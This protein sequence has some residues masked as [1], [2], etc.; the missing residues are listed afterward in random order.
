MSK[1]YD[2][3]GWATRNDLKCSDGRVIRQGAFKDQD[4]V[5]VPL[6]WNHNH[7]E[8]S[9]V[10]GHAL[11]LNRPEGIYTYG[12]FNDTEAG[13]LAKMLVTHGDIQ[14]LSIY[15][16]Q[17][18]QNGRDVVH[19]MIREVSL[20]LAGANPGAYIDTILTHSDDHDEEAIIY[21][22]DFIEHS[23]GIVID[24][25]PKE[26]PEVKETEEVL[27]HKDKE[28]EEKD[29]NKENGEGEPTEE[30]K[31]PENK[32]EADKETEEEKP[33]ANEKEK[34]VKEVFD[35][36]TEEQKN[37]VY[38]LIG[39]A[40]EDAKNE[41]KDDEDGEEMK[42]NLFDSET[43]RNVL[44][45]SDMD[46]IMKNA[47]R[48]GSLKDAYEG[49]VQENFLQHADDEEDD[50]YAN[51]DYGMEHINYLFP[52]AQLVGDRPQVVKREDS[53]V[54]KFLNG[55]RHTPFSRVKSVYADLTEDDAR[56]KGYIKGTQKKNEVFPLFKRVTTPTTVYKKQQL[57][58]DDVLDLTFD[59]V[60]WLKG[61]MRGMLNEEL[62]RAAL[63]GDGRDPS[64]DEKI[65][66]SN[67]RPIYKDTTNDVYAIKVAVDA[68]EDEE[69]DA[70]A[71]I[72]AAIKARADFRGTGKPTLYCTTALMTN[73][74]LLEDN[75]GRR[76]YATEAELATALRVAEIVE[77]PVM[78]AVSR[79]EGGFTY[80]LEGIIVNPK[81]YTFGADKGGEVSMFDDF[82]ID[83]N[84][85]KYL[86][87]TRCSGA[88]TTPKSA[89]VIERKATSEVSA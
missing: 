14:H 1:T 33:M 60:P 73:M 26:E 16:N 51:V 67:I 78:D 39:Q 74:L 31:E 32:E 77:V 72:K 54:S 19:G 44:T 13:K 71:F 9:N 85:Q 63:L 36:L 88:L 58:R 15:A 24:D 18:K 69:K 38:A 80:E 43:N 5:E 7:N 53:W 70:K 25:D 23:D 29:S 22:E 84:Q 50:T 64:S 55:A 52:D 11:L 30:V 68:K 2:F 45:H 48:V 42:H 86:I 56:A 34:T 21:N 27:E 75:M 6:V 17:L 3:G 41:G 82:D 35:T 10:L 20:V 89:L 76:L 59:I 83:F 37:V 61:E 57:D 46:E 12:S 79:E 47:K 49:Y 87:E 4:G 40:I 62:A 65:S 66:E 28:E 81:D 8:A